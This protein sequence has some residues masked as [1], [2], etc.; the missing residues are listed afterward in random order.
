MGIL[1]QALFQK[2]IALNPIR[3]QYWASVQLVIK[4]L[5]YIR[6][7]FHYTDISQKILANFEISYLQIGTFV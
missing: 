5:L 6:N 3:L 7:Q 2:F 4:V 1:A